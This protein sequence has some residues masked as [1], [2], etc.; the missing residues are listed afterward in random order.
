MSTEPRDL[1]AL[2]RDTLDDPA[3]EVRTRPDL[4]DDVVRGG[5]R[6]RRRRRAAASAGAALA[7]VGVV[8]LGAVTGTSLL[9]AQRSTPPPAGGVLQ[10]TGGPSPSAPA[11]TSTPTS[12]P[13]V[14]PAPGPDPSVPSALATGQAAVTTFGTSLVAVGSSAYLADGAPPDDVQTRVRRVDPVT[15]QTQAELPLAR[16]TAWLGTDGTRLWVSFRPAAAQGSFVAE[17]DPVTLA[18]LRTVDGVAGP[19]ASDGSTVW[20]GV[21][22]GA[23]TSRLVALDA[24]SLATRTTVDLA[25]DERP[26]DLALAAGGPLWVVLQTSTGSDTVA[27]DTGS[28]TRRASVVSDAPALPRLSAQGARVLAVTADQRRS[29]TAALL[30]AAGTPVVLTGNAVAGTWAGPVVWTHDAAGLRC[31]RAD[32]PGTV[33]AVSDG[34]GTDEVTAV[35]VAGDRVLVRGLDTLISL[36]VD[37]SCRG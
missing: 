27:L 5:T 4:L 14:T 6:L 33:S 19:L 36:A 7:L 32:A 23:P 31:R 3:H 34:G 1:D 9:D 13:T 16:G 26:T 2:L 29:G 25:A 17:L 15:L 30:S 20:V 11:P 21:D 12:Q 18:R 37:P 22:D 10:P 28:G 24:G 8:S 35:V